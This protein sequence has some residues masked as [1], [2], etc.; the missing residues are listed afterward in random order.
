MDADD[1]P[2]QAANANTTNN[3]TNNI[4]FIFIFSKI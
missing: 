4:F 2:V 3:P 1:P